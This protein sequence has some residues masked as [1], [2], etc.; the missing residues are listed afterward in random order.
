MI[1]SP[2]L[3]SPPWYFCVT[4]ND[5]EYVSAFDACS[6]SVRLAPAVSVS[7]DVSPENFPLTLVVTDPRHNWL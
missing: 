4:T 6:V 7:I 2:P 3:S 1:E 5:L